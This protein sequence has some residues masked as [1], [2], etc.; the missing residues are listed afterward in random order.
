MPERLAI[1]ILG[2]L[3]AACTLSVVPPTT[4]TPSIDASRSPAA[5]P[6][7]GPTRPARSA[8]ASATASPS[9]SANVSGLERLDLEAIGCPG[10]VVLE[11]SPSLAD[12]FHHYTALRSSEDEI[13]AAY[14]PIAPAVDWGDTYATDRFV[15]S[16]VDASLLPTDATWRYRVMAYDEVNRP[17][18]ASVVVQAQLEEVMQLG[19]VAIEAGEQPGST[20]LDWARFN[21]ESRCFSAYR[22]LVGAP[23]TVP[24]T[25]LS[26][27][28]IQ[29]TS[30]L[31][32]V[33]LQRGEAYAVR[34]EAIRSTTLGSFVVGR[35]RVA[36]YAVP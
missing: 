22:I 10:G 16:A 7:S 31:E 20:L 21:G 9:A 26:V 36:T 2:V 15:T 12:D 28:S 27:V 35:S 19:S 30:H 1:A 23:G 14:P 18:A 13:N 29:G 4:P 6:S 17:V 11:W 32:S 25:T 33:T 5:S 24:A 8:E 34:V 3:A